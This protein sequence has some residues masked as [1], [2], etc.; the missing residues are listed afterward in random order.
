MT[1]HRIACNCLGQTQS[2]FHTRFIMIKAQ[3]FKLPVGP[4]PGWELD[5]EVDEEEEES[6]LKSVAES[7]VVV[8][9]LKQ[10]R[11][12]WLA[13]TFPKFSS[14]AR[15]GKASDAVPPPHTIRSLG[16]CDLLIGPHIFSSTSLYEVHYLPSAPSTL[17]R[18]PAP[19]PPAPTWHPSAPY[20]SYIPY[21]QHTQPQ[22]H[23]QYSQNQPM[24]V[25]AT[26]PVQ[27]RASTPLVSSVVADTPITSALIQQVNSAAGS[28]PILA[29][30]LQLAA[31]GKATADQLKTLGILIQTLAAGPSTVPPP[32]TTPIN[33][34]YPMQAS[35]QRFTPAPS[36]APST[37]P[38]P[39]P[40]GL[41]T[42]SS[43]ASYPYPG[44]QFTSAPQY[45]PQPATYPPRDFDIIIEFPEKPN[46]R[47][48]FPR[49]AVICERKPASGVLEEINLTTALPF[50][51]L[52]YL[53]SKNT[54]ASVQEGEQSPPVVP[55]EVVT[56]KFTKVQQTV[57]DSLQRWSGGSEKLQ[58]NRDA[59]L[60]IKAPERAFLRYQLREG[61]LLTQLRNVSLFR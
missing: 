24:P 43:Y 7:F 38:T 27:Q 36:S 51:K 1:P 40:S 21:G 8:S 5:T 29:N 3:D 47:W 55:Q 35:E 50:P 20:G 14:K 26:A 2:K 56:F 31:S 39:A 52:D 61:D 4:K 6:E 28:D 49:G 58:E 48:V 15:G 16:K 19:M 34:Y 13:S 32:Q 9:S 44:H 12:N 17:A 45:I 54:P 23:P 60:K 33:T 53:T 25:A 59:L 18:P 10:S 22:Q 42:P 41:A 30:H 37:T 57:W 46:D 11:A